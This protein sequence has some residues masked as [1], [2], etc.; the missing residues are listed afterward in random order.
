MSSESIFTLYSLRI[1]LFSRVYCS[2]TV[3]PIFIAFL[4]PTLLRESPRTHPLPHQNSF[5]TPYRRNRTL[6]SS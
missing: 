3:L 5:R 4:L 6:L 2:D 1:S